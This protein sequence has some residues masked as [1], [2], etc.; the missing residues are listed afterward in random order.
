[1][2]ALI[3]RVFLALFALAGGIA[4]ALGLAA[5]T[6]R[7]FTNGTATCPTPGQV[8]GFDRMGVLVVRDLLVTQHIAMVTRETAAWEQEEI[9]LIKRL[10][11][12]RFG[13][14][15]WMSKDAERDISHIRELA[16]S[17][18]EG[19]GMVDQTA[20]AIQQHFKCQP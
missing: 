1:M 13:I 9:A 10:D 7:G 16:D 18:R 8:K 5:L 11:A 19:G 12:D 17:Y 4:A 6:G 3:A 15:N 20:A 14:E 2:Y